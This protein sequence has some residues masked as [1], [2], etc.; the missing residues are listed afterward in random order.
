MKVNCMALLMIKI[1][2]QRYIKNRMWFGWWYCY[3]YVHAVEEPELMARKG[4][5]QRDYR[6]H[7]TPLI[8]VRKTYHHHGVLSL[9][10]YYDA[11]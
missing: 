7:N 2:I 11:V 8:L 10:K 4:K 1:D 9:D 5:W 3:H 6:Y